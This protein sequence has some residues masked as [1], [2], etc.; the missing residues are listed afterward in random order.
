VPFAFLFGLLR[1]RVAS[2]AVVSDVVGRLG[3][4]DLRRQGLQG[5]RFPLP[6]WS[7]PS[8]LRATGRSPRL[9]RGLAEF[10]RSRQ[11]PPGTL[12]SPPAEGAE[13]PP[14]VVIG[15][16]K[17]ADVSGVAVAVPQQHGL[18]MV[19]EVVP[20]DGDEVRLPLD[21]DRAV[22]TVGERVVVHPDVGRR[23]L[24]VDRVVVPVAEVD[25]PD[26]YV[27]VAV[28]VETAAGDGGVAADPDLLT[29]MPSP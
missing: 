14:V 6:R 7:D 5:P 15:H 16:A 23:L 1:S 12:L 3:D 17:V 4:P 9:W 18:V 22:V 29:W 13:S 2:A 24:D 20:R 27:V 25:I 28:D 26:D 8:S 19:V 11:S 10:P 21:V